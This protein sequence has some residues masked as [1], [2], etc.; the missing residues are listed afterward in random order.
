VLGI[1][2]RHADIVGVNVDLRAGAVGPDAGTNTTLDA[3]KEKLA[4]V[5]E[6]A[7]DRFDDLELNVLC[8]FTAV[9]DDR[10]GLAGKL[11]GAFNVSPADLL[12]S[13]HVLMGTVDQLCDD[14]VRQRD[15]L[16]ISYIT[17]QGEDAMAALAPVVGKLT[18][19]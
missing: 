13:P 16:G 15:E 4:W 10:E 8:F 1:A 12:A 14:L 17:V 9:V 2:G 7:G 5:R 18:G 3:T 11:A 6:A 19:S